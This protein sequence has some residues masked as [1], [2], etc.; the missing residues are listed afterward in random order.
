MEV[1]LGLD[2]SKGKSQ[3]MAGEGRRTE[4]NLILV[5]RKGLF[6]RILSTTR[7]I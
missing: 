7:R 4:C 3:L 2:L 5:D 6:K 1:R